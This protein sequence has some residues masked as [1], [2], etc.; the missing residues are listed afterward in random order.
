MH[1]E[2]SQKSNYIYILN[3]ADHVYDILYFDFL[4]LLF[5][6]V[7]FCTL[8]WQV[9]KSN[10]IYIILVVA[11]IMHSQCILK[12]F[13]FKEIRFCQKARRKLFILSVYEFIFIFFN[14][15]SFKEGILV[16]NWYGL[17]HIQLDGAGLFL[18]VQKILYSVD[19]QISYILC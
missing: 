11:C 4:H 16:G 9:Q 12:Y 7:S 2:E 14:K 17:G 6:F 18:F 15:Y 1:G 19:Q 10:E 8:F 5:V 13:Q 3:F